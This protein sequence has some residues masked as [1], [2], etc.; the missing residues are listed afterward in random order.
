MMRKIFIH[1]S[2]LVALTVADS[3]VTKESSGSWIVDND[4]GNKF[5]IYYDPKTELVTMEA[6]VKNDNWLGVG[7]GNSMENTDMITFYGSNGGK[8]VDQW[9]EGWEAPKTDKE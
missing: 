5:K 8:V 1:L 9:S 2:S 3:H 7:F 6:E 4:S